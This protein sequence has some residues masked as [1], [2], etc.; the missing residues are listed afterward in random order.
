MKFADT[1]HPFYKPLWRRL[2]IIAVVALWAAYEVLV[3]RESLWIA[4]SLGMLAYAVWVFL[5]SWPKTDEPQK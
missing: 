5:I 2:V 1:G 3:S 4:I